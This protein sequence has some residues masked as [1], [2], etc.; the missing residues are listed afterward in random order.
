M[1]IQTLNSVNDASAP[2]FRAY[3]QK[4]WEKM[5]KRSLNEQLL[6]FSVQ[7]V[8]SAEELEE[9]IQIRRSAYARH[10]PELAQTL[11]S[12]EP[13]DFQPGSV[14]FLAKS[15]LD[16]SALGTARLQTNEFA[17]LPMQ[18]S[19]ELPSRFTSTR[20]CEV[21]RLGVQVGSI[22]RAVK[23]ALVKALFEY[24]E[25]TGIEYAMLAARSPVDRQ[26]AQL[27]FE[28]V[29]PEAGFIPMRHAAN[30]PHRVMH[31]EIATGEERWAA[32]KHPLLTYFRQTFHP[33]IRIDRDVTPEQLH[34]FW[35]KE[36]AEPILRMA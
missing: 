32:A 34:R 31:F 7:I 11:S 2:N 10:V 15:K 23:V 35:M 26:Y 12:P 17:D 14:V 28:D 1:N 24:C 19:V 16:D 27:M 21:S 8:Q 22:G 18:A 5:E 13:A 25:A 20:L 33:D 3:E 36:Q 29:F 30:L 4:I 9:A 6:P